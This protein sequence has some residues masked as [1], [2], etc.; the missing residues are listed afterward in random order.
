MPKTRYVSRN[1][2]GVTMRIGGQVVS[3]IAARYTYYCAECLGP[4]RFLNNGLACEANPEQHRG[5][6]SKDEAARLA[7]EQA[8]QLAQVEAD[9]EIVNG[10]IQPKRLPAILQDE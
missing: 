8:A 10:Q 3:K 9:Y 2:F 4:L 1:N 7:A 5:F 6:V